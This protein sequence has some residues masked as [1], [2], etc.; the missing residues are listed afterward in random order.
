MGAGTACKKVCWREPTSV[1]RIICTSAFGMGLD[2]SN[3]RMV[4][5]WQHP[6]SVE[7]YLQELVERDVTGSHPSPSF[8]IPVAAGATILTSCISWLKRLSRVRGSTFYANRSART[9]SSANRSYSSLGGSGWLLP[10]TTGRLFCRIK[11]RPSPQHLTWLLEWVFADR[12]VARKNAA[13]CDACCRRMIRR[14]G[15]LG[16]VQSVLLSGSS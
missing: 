6:S 11:K 16:F 9:Q 7:D 10:A 3:V 8:F 14:R 1:D 2:V 12:G 4:I 15:Q 13:C 5:H